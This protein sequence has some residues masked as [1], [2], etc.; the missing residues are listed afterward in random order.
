MIDELGGVTAAAVKLALDAATLR[1]QVIANNVANAET[2]GFA[3]ARVSFEA[4]LAAARA[5]LDVSDDRALRSHLDDL[6]A[7]LASPNA[8]RRQGEG[9]VELDAE[10]VELADNSIRYQ[11]LLEG[12]SKQMAIVRTAIEEGRS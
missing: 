11:A 1:H 7:R 2:P 10:M 12:I 6:T 5:F 4:H 9:P 8:I 3:P